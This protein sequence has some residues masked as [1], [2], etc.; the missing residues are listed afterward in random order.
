[1]TPIFALFI[2]HPPTGYMQVLTFA[3]AF[4]RALHVIALADQQLVLRLADY[5]HG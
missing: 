1:V 4:D 5:G 3:T 2:T